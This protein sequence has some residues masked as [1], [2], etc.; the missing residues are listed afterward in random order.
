LKEGSWAREKLGSEN[1][2]STKAK[3]SRRLDKFVI[4]ISF[5]AKRQFFGSPST[6]LMTNGDILRLVKFVRAC[7]HVEA[8]R[9][10][11][12]TCLLIIFLPTM[13]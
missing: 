1:S 7:E 3:R 5:C 4:R 10:F 13:F 8:F 11:S 2:T 9:V 6:K 12:A